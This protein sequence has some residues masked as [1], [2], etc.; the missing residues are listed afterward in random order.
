MALGTRMILTLQSTVVQIRFLE[1]YSRIFGFLDRHSTSTS[2]IANWSIRKCYVQTQ[3]SS[4]IL[5]PRCQ[6]HWERDG[7]WDIL[8]PLGLGTRMEVRRPSSIRKL[9]LPFLP[10]HFALRATLG[11]TYLHRCFCITMCVWEDI[12][13]WKEYMQT[14]QLSRFYRESPENSCNLLVSR[15][16]SN[17]PDFSEYSGNIIKNYKYTVFSNII[18]CLDLFEVAL[19]QFIGSL[20]TT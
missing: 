12:S 9:N 17:S 1:R 19:W 4:C 14:F 16:L 15:F 2:I 11:S 6:A 8:V 13:I 7:K 3:P 20:I 5:L 18:V 10:N